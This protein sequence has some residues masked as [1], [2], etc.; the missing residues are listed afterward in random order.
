MRARSLLALAAL[1]APLLWAGAPASAVTTPP[2]VLVFTDEDRQVYTAPADGSADPTPL[3]TLHGR[4]PALSPDGTRLAYEALNGPADGWYAGTS[5]FVRPADGSGSPVDLTPSTS[6][7]V[8]A[9]VPRWSAD[10]IRIAYTQVIDHNPFGADRYARV[11]RADGTAETDVA[12]DQL[13]D[14]WWLRGRRSAPSFSPSARQLAAL[15]EETSGTPAVIRVLTRSGSSAP[16]AGTAGARAPLWSPDGRRIAFIRG[17]GGCSA[18]LLTVAVTGGPLTGV[19]A[20][21]GVLVHAAAYSRD[22]GR[23]FWSESQPCGGPAGQR[24]WVADGSGATQLATAT[25]VGGHQLQFEGTAGGPAAPADTTPPPAP[26]VGAGAVTPTSASIAWNVPAPDATEYV[27]VRTA[28]GAPAPLTPADGVVV[29]DGALRAATIGGL[30]TGTAYDLSV[31][32]VDASGNV[33]APSAARTVRPAAL[34]VVSPVGVLRGVSPAFPVRWAGGQAPY[35]VEVRDL[36][37]PRRARVLTTSGTAVTVP[38]VEGHTYDV[39]VSGGTDGFGNAVRA[40]PV[41]AVV[42]LD[43]AA[44]GLAY[45]PGWTAPPGGGDRYQGTVHT[46][47]RAGSTLTLTRVIGRL[48]VIGDRCPSCGRFQV[49]IDGHS[50]GPVDTYAASR[51]PRRPLADFGY[52]GPGPHTVRLVVLATPGRTKVILDAIAV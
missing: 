43:D 12:T 37:A 26:V 14:P 2:E 24:I 6:S 29:F 36:S 45:G 44:P 7:Y 4:H 46:S 11:V 1:T 10:G 16:V 20:A 19:R 8:T 13:A 23:L 52:F 15:Y 28:H 51:L 48:V 21:A 22:G 32:A 39:R 49:T 30:A 18:Q 35:R 25:E 50:W 40:E 3:G 47:S 42:P 31:F 41:T 5:V 33:S 17:A 38:G 27:V 34:E 9:Q